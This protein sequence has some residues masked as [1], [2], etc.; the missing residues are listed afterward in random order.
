MD[1]CRG[2]DE[3]VKNLM[4]VELEGAKERREYQ[5]HSVEFAKQNK[6]I[7]C[8]IAVSEPA[9]SSPHRVKLTAVR[10]SEL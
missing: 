1:E 5:F 3:D 6:P 2:H 10:S 7:Y 4:R 9:P 8:L